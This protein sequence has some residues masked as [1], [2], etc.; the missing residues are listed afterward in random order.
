METKRHKE[1]RLKYLKILKEQFKLGKLN[2]KKYKKERKCV[3][4]Y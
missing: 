1:L 4:S 2:K 3:K